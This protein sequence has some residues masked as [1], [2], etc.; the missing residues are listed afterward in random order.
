MNGTRVH[1]A[2]A[3]LAAIAGALAALLAVEYLHQS[4]SRTAFG[5]TGEAAASANYVLALLGTTTNDAT[6]IVLI[7]TKTQTLMVYEYMVSRHTMYLRAARTYVADR[8]LRD[9]GF[10][11]GDSYT[12]PSV[13]D[14]Q[15]LIK[16]R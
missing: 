10:F 12:G 9:N 16:R 6:P 11:A 3:G 1:W 2:V 7:D 13:N 14:V 15:N 8:E 4:P 5:Q